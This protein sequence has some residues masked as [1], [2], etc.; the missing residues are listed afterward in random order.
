MVLIVEAIDPP[1]AQVI[2][3]WGNGTASVSP[4]DLRRLWSDWYRGRGHVV[5]GM[6]QVTLPADGGLSGSSRLQPDGTLVITLTRFGETS[7]TIMTRA[8]P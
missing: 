3:A 7:R 5:E 2:L 4:A 6:S 1:E 8:Q